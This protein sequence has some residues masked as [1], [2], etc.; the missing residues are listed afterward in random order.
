MKE[1]YLVLYTLYYI[2]TC[3]MSLLK[4]LVRKR[5]WSSSPEENNNNVKRLRLYPV[6]RNKLEVF[7]E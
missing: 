6:P 1:Q 5:L 2:T 3:E 7:F 4:W